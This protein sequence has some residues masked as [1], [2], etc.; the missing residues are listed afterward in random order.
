MID[1]KVSAKLKY[2]MLSDEEEVLWAAK[3]IFAPLSE[4]NVKIIGSV[5]SLVI[6][7]NIFAFSVAG[8]QFRLMADKTGSGLFFISTLII[9]AGLIWVAVK[10]KFDSFMITNYAL[11]VQ[12][13]GFFGWREGRLPHH[14]V[15]K[16]K[17]LFG[18][19]TCVT[20][21]YAPLNNFNVAWNRIWDVS[22]SIGF[23]VRHAIHI[24]DIPNIDQFLALLNSKGHPSHE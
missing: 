22:F 2:M 20:V 7:W 10:P 6:L 9:F 8:P 1:A 21:S 19:K 15:L 23:Y 17:P 12:R 5:A 13:R 11:Y 24:R 16:A 3:P 14:N 4:Y 18:M